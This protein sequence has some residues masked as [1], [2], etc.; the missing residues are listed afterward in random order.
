MGCLPRCRALTKIKQITPT[1]FKITASGFPEVA[2]PLEVF[3][4]PGLSSSDTAGTR[5]PQGESV[6]S[7]THLLWQQV[8]VLLVPALGGV[9][10]LNQS[11][12]LWRARGQAGNSQEWPPAWA[13]QSS[14]RQRMIWELEGQCNHFQHAL[15]KRLPPQ[16]HPCLGLHN[17]TEGSESRDEMP[18]CLFAASGLNTPGKNMRMGLGLA[19]L[20]LLNH[21]A[22]A[23]HGKGEAAPQKLA[24][25]KNQD[26]FL[27]D[28]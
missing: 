26:R 18:P 2:V 10:E 5:I 4:S 11:Q 1:D 12:S 24:A 27:Q 3:P 20:P 25:S 21:P 19:A 17:P 23:A 28:R 22:A 8:N 7:L 6:P 15:R 13:A 14:Q 9:V 16:V